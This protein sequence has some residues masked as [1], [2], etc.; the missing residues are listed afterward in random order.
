MAADTPDRCLAGS[1][2][3]PSVGREE[4]DVDLPAYLLYR[5]DALAAYRSWPVPAAIISD[6]AYGVRGFRGDTVGAGGLPDWYRPHVE[7][8]SQYAT[9]ATTLW[10]WNTELGWATVHPLLVQSGW[11]YVQAVIW[12]KGIGHVAGNVNGK[13]IRRFPVVTEVCAFYCRRLDICGAGGL[14]PVQQWLRREWQRSGLSLARANE[15]CGVRNAATRKYLTQDWLWYW[16][17]GE[18]IGRLAAYANRHGSKSGWPYYSLDGQVPVSAKD[19]DALRHRWHHA[20]GMTNVWR[21]PPLHGVERIKGTMRRAAPRVHSPGILSAAHLNQKPLE[22]MRRIITA[23]TDP[24]DVVWEPFGGLAS[25]SVAAV[26]TG[27]LAC[28]AE[29]DHDFAEIAAQRL[30]DALAGRDPE[31]GED[32]PARQA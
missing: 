20:H 29:I 27:R 7:A 26:E 28:T 21:L 19:W 17:S 3:A 6:G 24:G 16:P 5:G 4:T 1:G 2:A 31:S 23:A 9:P 12:D 32:L 15:A 8:W 10:F 13:T 22:L 18:M 14:M 11:D 25:A 30:D